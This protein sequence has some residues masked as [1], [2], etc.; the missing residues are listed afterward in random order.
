MGQAYY[1]RK[2]N[3][4][5]G[6]RKG[7]TVYT[8]QP[9][10]Y[11]T[12]TTKQVANQI[13]QESALTPADVLGVLERLAYFCQ[14]HMSLGYK[15]K[16]DG[17]GVLYNDLIT[18][19]SVTTEEEATAK[20]V[21]SVRPAFN[22]EYTI[23][24]GNFRYALLPEKNSLTRVSFNGTQTGAPEEDLNPDGGTGGGTEPGGEDPLG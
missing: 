23:V 16:L 22:P 21:K 9:Y 5:I 1:V 7:E 8:V 13:A 12:I 17:L 24:N 6:P 2:I 19:G 3:L 18:T 4:K 20:L 15:V 11:G 10:Y 14:T